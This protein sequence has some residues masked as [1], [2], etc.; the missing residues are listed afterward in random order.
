MPLRAIITQGT[1]ADCT[2][3][4]D[5]IK[6]ISAQYLLVAC[7]YDS[8]NIICYAKTQ[9]MSPVIPPRKS[10]KEQREYDKELYKQDTWWKMLFSI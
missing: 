7:G 3:A 5:L 1:T 4:I 9:G 8:N 2:Q 6:G 10:R